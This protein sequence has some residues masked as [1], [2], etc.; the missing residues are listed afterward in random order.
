MQ[1]SILPSVIMP[2]DGSAY[3]DNESYL[4]AFFKHNVLL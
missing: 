4:T 1:N 2:V 3:I